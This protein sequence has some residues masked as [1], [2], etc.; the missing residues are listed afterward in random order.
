MHLFVTQF[1]RD[2]IWFAS[3]WADRSSNSAGDYSYTEVRDANT[4][5]FLYKKDYFPTGA[6]G[7]F[8][9]LAIFPLIVGEAALYLVINPAITAFGYLE[10]PFGAGVPALLMASTAVGL[11]WYIAKAVFLVGTRFHDKTRAWTRDRTVGELLTPDAFSL[12]LVSRVPAFVI[13]PWLCLAVVVLIL[14]AGISLL[15]GQ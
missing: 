9:V 4:G 2:L 8:I 11:S 3:D 5:A 7:T 6:V 1:L 10:I 14:Y 15:I 12:L 13:A